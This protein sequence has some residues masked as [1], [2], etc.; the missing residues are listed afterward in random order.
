[1]NICLWC[2]ENYSDTNTRW[3]WGPNYHGVH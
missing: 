3:H 2:E 1:M